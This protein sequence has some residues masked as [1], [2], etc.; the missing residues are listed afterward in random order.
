MNDILVVAPH[1]DDETLGCGG[2][3]LKW[4]SQGADLHWLIVTAM[5]PE[6][7][8]A[9]DRMERRRHQIDAV[10]ARYGFASVHRLDCPTTRLDTLPLGDLVARIAPVVAETRPETIL[11]P[12]PGD[13]HSDH[14]IVFHA[15]AATTK[16]FRSP[17]VR[18]VLAY[19]TLSETDF[20]LDPD[21]NGFRPNS[22]CGIG[23][24][25]DEKVAIL[26]L[27]EE[28]LGPFPFPRSEQAVR[29]LAALRGVAAGTDAAEAFMILKEIV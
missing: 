16:V 25:L 26:K 23:P 6:L 11:L 29:A 19:E 10:A 22:F 14:G 7:G 28:E 20:A 12:Y 18:R 13:P 2:S 4:R 3:L 5:C 27:Y 21:I 15:C 17:H 1:P 24:W 9:P 8:F